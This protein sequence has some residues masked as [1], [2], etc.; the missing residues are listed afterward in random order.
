MGLIPEE[1]P[2]T[3]PVDSGYT[4]RELTRAALQ[5]HQC[6]VKPYKNLSDRFIFAKCQGFCISP[7]SAYQ[8]DFETPR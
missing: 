3:I 1:L 4:K 6:R 2:V 5:S 8:N 7:A